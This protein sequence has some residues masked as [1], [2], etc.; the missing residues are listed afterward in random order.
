MANARWQSQEDFSKELYDRALRLWGRQRA[1]ALRK[2]INET[3][4][5]LL[6]VSQTLPSRE[7]HP[8]FLWQNNP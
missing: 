1:E 7:L 6:R 8:A 4:E 3:S 2:S 5:Q